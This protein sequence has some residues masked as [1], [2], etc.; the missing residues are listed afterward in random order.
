MKRTALIAVIMVVALFGVAVYAN[1]APTTASTG[2]VAV[3][4]TTNPKV[5]ITIPTGIDL[6]VLEPGTANTVVKKIEGKSNRSA[7]MTAVV[8]TGT[9]TN[10]T[11][12]TVDA[13]TG[14]RGGSIA[15]NYSVSGMAS[16]DNPNDNPAGS[17]VFTLAQ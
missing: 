12:T 4:A 8:T 13:T 14:L 16:Y 17:I 5:E 10:L 6:G 15:V 2:S 1:A 11:A 7:T 9:F 3:T